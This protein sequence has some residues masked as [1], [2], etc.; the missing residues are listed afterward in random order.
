[1]REEI[2]ARQK[3][4]GVIPPDTALTKRPAEISAWDDMPAALKPVLERTGCREHLAAN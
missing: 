1:L 2:I 3:T 4:L